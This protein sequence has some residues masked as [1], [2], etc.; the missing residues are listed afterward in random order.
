MMKNVVLGKTGFTV[1]ELCFGALPMGPLQKN[2]SIEDGAD[3]IAYALEKGV[4]FIDTAQM[5][6]TYEMVREGVKRSGK[7]PV[8]STKCAGTSYEEMEK[9]V[10]EALAAL[11]RKQ[12]DIFLLHAARVGDDLFEIRAGAWQCLKDYKEKGIIKAIGASTHNVKTVLAAA[13]RDD[14]DVIFPLI[15]KAGRGV[16]DGSLADM[17]NAIEFCHERN[18]G[19]FFMKIVAGGTLISDFK[20]AFDYGMAISKGRVSF[21]VG[22]LKKSEVDMNIKYFEGESIEDELKGLKDPGKKFFVFRALCKKCGLCVNGCHSDAIQIDEVAAC[23]DPDVCIRCGYCV[24]E[25]PEFA[26]R[27]I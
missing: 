20:P 24:G 4:T 1:S 10:H 13:K 14:V 11:D 19:V 26:I 27:M 23:I 9:A 21:A 3:L 2:L 22:M 15:N 8:I 6:R 5:Y 17:E 12:L 18:I 16:L 7:N 25:C